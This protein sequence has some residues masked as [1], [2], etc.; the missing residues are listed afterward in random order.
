MCCV[1][2]CG[3]ARYKMNFLYNRGSLRSFAYPFSPDI[4]NSPHRVVLT[5]TRPQELPQDRQMAAHM[6]TSMYDE[7]VT[8]C[9]PHFDSK[10]HSERANANK[11]TSE[12]VAN[13]CLV[14]QLKMQRA[15]SLTFPHSCSFCFVKRGS[16]YYI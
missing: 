14:F 13:L 11:P 16:F 9:V 15:P 1:C 12:Q 10:S 7:T 4:Q 8:A 5:Q 6:H 3:R 2:V